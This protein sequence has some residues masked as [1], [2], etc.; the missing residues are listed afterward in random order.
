MD[1][2]LVLL[3]EAEAKMQQAY[4]LLKAEGVAGWAFGARRASLPVIQADLE[5]LIEGME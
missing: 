4:L 5:S 3:R 2:A 1:E